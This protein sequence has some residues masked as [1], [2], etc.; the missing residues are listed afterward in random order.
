METK[1][2]LEKLTKVLAKINTIEV[3]YTPEHN[4][5]CMELCYSMQEVVNHLDNLVNKGTLDVEELLS[6]SRRIAN[7]CLSYSPD[8]Q[9]IR[10]K[11]KL[12]NI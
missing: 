12:I 1:G 10:F 11:K 9:Q 6:S 2:T 4:R 5:L 7:L 3:P 8:P